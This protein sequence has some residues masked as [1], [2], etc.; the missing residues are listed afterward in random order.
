MTDK[1]NKRNLDT[2]SYMCLVLS[3][4][5]GAF[6]LPLGRSLLGV[7]VALLCLD[8]MG[9]R[10]FP[11]IPRTAWIGLVFVFSLV[12]ST[13]LSERFCLAETKLDKL[14][15]F[16]GLPA[17]ALLIS[18]GW[19]LVGV[20]GGYSLGTGVLA[21]KTYYNSVRLCI[22]ATDDVAD[23]LID[24]KTVLVNHGSMTDGQR[25][26][27]GIIAVTGIVYALRK[28]GRSTVF[29][30]VL[31]VL[32]CVGLVL[33]LKRGS[34]ICAFLMVGVFIILKTNWRYIFLL[35]AA[36]VAIGFLPPV[37]SRI[38]AIGGEFS[39]GKGGRVTMWT[40]IA[41][42]L[43]SRKPLMGMGYRMLTNEEMVEIAPQVERHRDHLHSNL[44]Q[45]LVDGGIVGLF[46]YMAWMLSG[47]VDAVVMAVRS[48]DGGLLLSVWGLVSALMFMG[49][50]LHGMVEYNFGDGEIVLLYG[51]TM[52]CC[53]SWAN[54]LRRGAEVAEDHDFS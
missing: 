6:S 8:Y 3:V 49:L 17:T 24:Y 48:R 20:L 15:W 18:S 1:L 44:V 21:L 40:L 26:M 5:T 43:V 28:D 16:V 14:F 41:P 9:R 42:E 7:S 23:G 2:H 39:E 31:L 50:F 52:G 34:L 30:W 29:W 45:M 4:F 36:A 27:L 38:A 51:M 37:R 46:L 35:V 32:Q 53:A 47:T 19:R 54:I 22:G 11:R 25:F 10:K 33:T 13:V 12:T